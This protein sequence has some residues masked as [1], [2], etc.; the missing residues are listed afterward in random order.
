MNDQTLKGKWKEIKGEIQRAWGKI[1]GDELEET[2]GNMKAIAGIIQQKYGSEK[3]DIHSRL[4]DIVNRVDSG[5][6]EQRSRVA[7]A[8]EQIKQR[9]N[10]HR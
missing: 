9:L 2:Q 7:K 4:S 5:E 1:S 3:D 6:D 10:H 8:S